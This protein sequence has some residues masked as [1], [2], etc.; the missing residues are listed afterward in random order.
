MK[1]R[2]QLLIT[3]VLLSATFLIMLAIAQAERRVALILGNSSYTHSTPLRNSVNDATALSEAFT[4]LGF[5][6][7]LGIDQTKSDMDDKIHLFSKLLDGA[8]MAVFFYAG[9]GMQLNLKNYLV[10]IDFDPHANSN[11]ISQLISLDNIIYELEKEKRVS[12]IFLDACRNNPLV[13]TLVS[14]LASGRSL[15]IDENRGVKV[16][17]QGLAEVEGKAGTLIAYATQPGNVAADG[18][19]DNSP[20]TEGLLKYLEEPGIDIRDMLSK[21]RVSVMKETSDKQIPWDHSS[22]VKKVYFKKKKRK[23]APPP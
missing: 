22:L 11:L 4:R 10:P 18:D 2:N 23:F 13:D 12:I 6:V 7:V 16:V 1:K 17:G 20:F 5:N 9:H 21:V 3:L 15:P 8:N 14:N 19:G